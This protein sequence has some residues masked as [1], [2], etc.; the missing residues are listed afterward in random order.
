M[1]PFDPVD[2]EPVDPRP[3]DETGQHF[4]DSPPCTD[5]TPVVVHAPRAMDILRGNPPS[6]WRA[7]ELSPGVA[8]RI[9]SGLRTFE[10]RQQ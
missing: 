6:E 8:E 3:L 2:F 1:T 7:V 4:A 10:E 5:H 9:R